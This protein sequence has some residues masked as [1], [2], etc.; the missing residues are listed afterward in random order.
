MTEKEQLTILVIVKLAFICLMGLYQFQGIGRDFDFR[1]KTPA[2]EAYP[3]EIP[4][5]H[6]RRGGFPDRPRKASALRSNQ[7]ITVQTLTDLIGMRDKYSYFIVF[8]A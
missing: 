5:A 3:G 2:G 6:R 8:R 1:S 4:Q 7:R